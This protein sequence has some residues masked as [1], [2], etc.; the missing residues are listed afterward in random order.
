MSTIL[1][2]TFHRTRYTTSFSL[3]P[4]RRISNHILLFFWAFLDLFFLQHIFPLLLSMVLSFHHFKKC[5]SHLNM[6]S[7]ILS[8]IAK[9]P[10][11]CILISYFVLYSPYSSILPFLSLLYL[12]TPH[13]PILRSEH[14]CRP[15]YCIINLMFL[16]YIGISCCTNYLTLLSTSST[17]I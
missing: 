8:T 14:H 10:I 3:T 17:H 13:C 6:F 15:I 11:I 5:S 7:L 1:E 16:T 2:L 9:L 12:P 4:T